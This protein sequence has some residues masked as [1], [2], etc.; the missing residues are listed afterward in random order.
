MPLGSK[1]KNPTISVKDGPNLDAFSRLRV[2]EAV[3]LFDFQSQY[4]DLDLLW[5][6]STSGGSVSNNLDEPSV[7]ISNGGTS[8][9]NYA[10]RQTKIYYRYQPGYSQ[11]ILNSF[12]LGE[13]VS[14]V[15][16]YIGYYDGYNG[17][18]LKYNNSGTYF[19][20][21]SSSIGS[22]VDYEVH[23]N[24]W[25]LDRF[26]G[27]GPSG[28]IIDFTKTQIM[29][30]DF[31]WLGVGR[32]R[33][34]FDIDGILYYA[35]QFLN[36]NN[37]QL[38]YMATANLPIRMEIENVGT[39]GSET[40]L[41]HIC[42]SIISEGGFDVNRGLQFSA[43]TGTGSVAVT[44]RQ[45]ILSL[46][47]ATTGPNSVIN[48]GEIIFKNADI[49]ATT[50]TCLYEIVLN[51]TLTG[52]SFSKFNS[53]YSVAEIDTDASAISE[54]LVIDSGYVTADTGGFFT[55][56]SS[57]FVNADIFRKL[58]IM[59]TQLNGEQ[60]VL[61]IVITAVTGTSNVNTAISWQEYY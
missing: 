50:N 49:V 6:K 8:D 4:G 26:D 2:S 48:T 16:K 53:D 59:Y 34:G 44:T 38:P 33:I 42:S 3:T 19:V 31:Q 21:R 11:F 22:T 51:G 12:V 40:E 13:A 20:K 32:V 45:P 61:S 54:G 46:R 56:G 47:A 1:S 30:I 58:P 25:N 52:A 41:K 27:T 23:Q 14:N 18:F 35:H 17:I 57:S 60:N 5:E 37:L 29:I 9:E 24:D 15:N 55:G 39:A 7:S 43:N 36:A 28:I 10:I